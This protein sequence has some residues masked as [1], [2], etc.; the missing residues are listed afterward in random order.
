MP[1]RTSFRDRLQAR[2]DERE[3]E[4][5][6]RIARRFARMVE[7]GELQ[8]PTGGVSNDILQSP[9][10]QQ[11]LS[12]EQQTGVEP[13]TKPQGG[14]MPVLGGLGSLVRKAQHAV[15]PVAGPAA[16]A[17]AQNIPL[18]GP[19]V[20]ALAPRP[21]TKNL[22]QTVG[23]TE[24]QAAKTYT[25]Q[26]IEPLAGYAA[27]AGRGLD[28]KPSTALAVA[29]VFAGG[30]VP[31]SQLP[32]PKLGELK[33]TVMTPKEAK[34]TYKSLPAAQ[35]TFLSIGVDP[36][37]LLGFGIAEKAGL[38][39]AGK[40]GILA[41]L[42]RG[43]GKGEAKY[44]EAANA[45]FQ[46]AGKAA[47]TIVP[48]SAR[49]MQQRT[50]QVAVDTANRVLGEQVGRAYRPESKALVSDLL[51]RHLTTPESLAPDEK[52]FGDLM[53]GL[54]SEGE[55]DTVAGRNLPDLL[56]S[57]ETRAG[58]AK[59]QKALKTWVQR[60]LLQDFAEGILNRSGFARAGEMWK[61][62]VG[63]VL[64]WDARATLEFPGYTLGNR[65]ETS[66]LWAM[67]GISP[68]LMGE[69]D[70]TRVYT[71]IEGV[72]RYL[73]RGGTKF[74][75]LRPTGQTGEMKGILHRLSVVE[76]D[77]A[78][79]AAVRRNGFDQMYRRTYT[80]ELT[81]GAAQ[82]PG[83]RSLLDM[84]A[85]P[86][87]VAPMGTNTLLTR[88]AQRGPEAVMTVAR[89]ISPVHA[90]RALFSDAI[91]RY[92][93]LPPA[94]QG[95]LRDWQRGGFRESPEKL[96]ARIRPEWEGW[97]TKETQSEPSAVIEGLKEITRNFQAAPRGMELEA[98]L[99]ELQMMQDWMKSVPRQQNALA[100]QTARELPQ[101]EKEAFFRTTDD[102]LRSDIGKMADTFQEA[103]N[104]ARP[105]TLK[106]RPELTS[107]LD[108]S[109]Q[110]G[111][112]IREGWDEDRLFRERYF[113][114]G[115]P[116]GKEE[117]AAFWEGYYNE[118]E[119]IWNQINAKA[120]E[121]EQASRQLRLKQVQAGATAR[122][123]L[124]GAEAVTGNVF[125]STAAQETRGQDWIKYLDSLRKPYA[126]RMAE[127]A[128]AAEKA[129]KPGASRALSDMQ[130]G[131]MTP[132]IRPTNVRNEA[133][134]FVEAWN[135]G[136][137][138]FTFPLE[139]LGPFT[140]KAE[141]K[142]A[143]AAFLDDLMTRGSA[144]STTVRDVVSQAQE[145]ALPIVH[146][147]RQQE[148]E[149]LTQD[150][151]RVAV[152]QPGLAEDVKQA[153]RV[154]N[155][156]AEISRQLTAADRKIL[157]DAEKKA[158]GEAKRIMDWVHVNYAD[159]NLV[160]A[161]MRGAG[162]PYW[163]YESRRF[164]R[165]GRYVA[166][167][168][169]FA[170]GLYEYYNNTDE[171]YFRV[172]G[173]PLEMSLLRGTGATTIRSVLQPTFD[174]Q[175]DGLIG[176]LDELSNKATKFGFY[177]MG[178]ELAIGV[179]SGH[180]GDIAPA[181]VQLPL[182]AG[183]ALGIPG[184][185]PLPSAFQE[186]LIRQQLVASGI[187]PD[188][189]TDE[190]R[191]A[192]GQAVA[193]ASI[194]SEL[195]GMMRLR[196]QELDQMKRGRLEAA[197]AAGVPKATAQDAFAE[198]RNPIT[199]VDDKEK[200]ILTATQ[201]D[202][203]VQKAAEL[204]GVEPDII[205]AL[206]DISLPLRAPGERQRSEMS[207]EYHQQSELISQGYGEQVDALA[208]SFQPGVNGQQVRDQ[209]SALKDQRW[210][211]RQALNDPQGRYAEI[212]ANFDNPE[213]LTRANREDLLFN[214]YME[215][216]GQPDLKDA[217][218]NY[219]YAARDAI[220]EG[221]KAT[222]GDETWDAIQTRLHKDEHPLER[223]L[224]LD[225]EK[226]SDYWGLEEDLWARMT[227]NEPSLRGVSLRQYTTQV[228][229]EAVQNG[230]DPTEDPRWGFLDEVTS[231]LS[232]VRD[233][234]RRR[235]PDINAILIKWGYASSAKSREAQA[236]FQQQYGWAPKLA[237]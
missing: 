150:L 111:K 113:A 158:A 214:L 82:S 30:S 47:S 8:P 228:Q 223:E 64:G 96:L 101:A 148:W 196:P 177:P 219:D 222:Y 76:A 149:A 181:G 65:A 139:K 138:D 176:K 61:N 142:N 94:V 233:I 140:T 68:G 62:T 154:V 133:G 123:R 205:R 230:I 235:H 46:A 225:Q 127:A 15:E 122:G 184:V 93:N 75:T 19:A 229:L 23:K 24:L 137:G 40:P 175:Q 63:K 169:G 220:D 49:G 211:A 165:I 5:R 109:E 129:L 77:G 191:T 45:P 99:E 104:A 132:W 217:L 2:R 56:S 226:I 110:I 97:V 131:G 87:T 162:L 218:G 88:A 92:S 178:L 57:I 112:T 166:G 163:V 156:V 135:I 157:A 107:T 37:N 100:M 54:F 151:Q 174:S 234:Y 13:Q 34:E 33:K 201:R 136:V 126:E 172:P 216:V 130:V 10:V 232:E 116:K 102:K 44:L 38:A 42:T 22:L 12:P 212:V 25:G 78:M 194:P 115:I 58:S 118:R 143:W 50:V 73:T 26:F 43:L 146:T 208:G 114:E 237:K 221:F 53:R 59:G 117:A 210:G 209:L 185:Q 60:P 152:E 16:K 72:P 171:G 74:T 204:A 67:E 32:R 187:D 35:K 41:A 128:P 55:L 180:L 106:E 89:D 144:A 11:L 182:Y 29:R 52:R 125:E 20:A 202:Q 188:K 9:I 66:G 231:T 134:E 203:A 14:S 164:P 3:S 192:A 207:K 141:A 119:G 79:D 183:Q 186:R 48:R 159:E 6:K 121:L 161:T 193:K 81:A 224:R 195:L 90:N 213:K 103:V 51:T 71:G 179:T 206:S 167:R 120:D 28:V 21:E 86:E 160:D 31:P 1:E 227:A 18:V 69:E 7:S 168:P 17:L 84:E 170:K 70:F 215:A 85:L 173:T 236:L 80:R 124:T 27:Q 83:V 98:R 147:R 190:E 189:A 145:R 153:H 39:A 199:A 4:R 95:A 200:Y 197:I 198:G 155:E 105:V 36:I 91:S 108:L